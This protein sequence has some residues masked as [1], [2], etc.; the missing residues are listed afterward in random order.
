MARCRRLSFALSCA[1]EL[2]LLAVGVGLG[3]LVGSP[4]FGNVDPSVDS[5]LVGLVCVIP[6]LGMGWWYFKSE[7]PWVVANRGEFERV[8]LPLFRGWSTL[9]FAIISALA[10][11]C[12]E[13]FFRGAI[14]GMINGMFGA[15]PAII[16]ASIAFGLA[17]YL[18][19]S[20]AVLTG[21]VGLYLGL[22]FSWSGNLWIPMLVHGLYDFIALTLFVGRSAEASAVEDS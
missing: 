11:V 8:A 6:L 15:G 20:Y 16:L 10:G 5:T 18:N 13:A 4:M 17:H 7:L 14:Q 21:L 9:Q 22:L 1:L 3:W 2:A 19:W 12:E